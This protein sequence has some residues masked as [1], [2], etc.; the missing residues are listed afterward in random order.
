[1]TIKDSFNYELIIIKAAHLTRRR[2][3][4]VSDG[5]VDDYEFERGIN[6]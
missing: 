4:H 6:E 3:V 1:M 5:F 2:L